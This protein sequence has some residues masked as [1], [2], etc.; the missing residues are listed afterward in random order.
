MKI[1]EN[2]KRKIKFI[3]FADIIYCKK[4]KYACKI[5]QSPARRLLSAQLSKICMPFSIVKVSFACLSTSVCAVIKNLYTIFN[6]QSFFCLLVDFCLRSYQKIC[7]SFSIIK[8][9][10]AYFSFQR[11][12]RSKKST[13]KEKQAGHSFGG[14]TTCLLF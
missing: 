10:F 3:G 13:V 1:I 11:K 9:S 6:N 5:K 7:I 8:V 4:D 2:W 12:V 14:R